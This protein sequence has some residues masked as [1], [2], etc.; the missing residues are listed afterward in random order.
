MRT[1]YI[2]LIF[3]G[4]LS[5]AF[6]SLTDTTPGPYPTRAT[7][8]NCGATDTNSTGCKICAAGKCTEAS[9]GYFIKTDQP[10]SCPRAC[11]TCNTDGTT[12]LTCV[13]PEAFTD[14][15]CTACNSGYT[16]D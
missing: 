7:P 2:A 4:C 14:N 5:L 10:A 3:V 12:C 16:F 11:A 1:F 15:T 6:G 9:P 13:I 8:V